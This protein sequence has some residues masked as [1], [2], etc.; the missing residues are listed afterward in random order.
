MLE[1]SLNSS[2]EEASKILFQA[3][4]ASLDAAALEGSDV[5]T[6][7]LFPSDYSGPGFGEENEESFQTLL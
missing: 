5:V 2:D 7:L 4:N 3:F 1:T 6:G